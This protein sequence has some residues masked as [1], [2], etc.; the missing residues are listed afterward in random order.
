MNEPQD[1][2]N[3]AENV[4]D[5][6][7]GDYD[8][9]IDDMVIPQA[10]EYKE[11]EIKDKFDSGFKFAFI[12]TGQGGSRIAETFHKIGYRRVGVV[13][14]AEQDLATIDLPA[15]NKFCFG[16]GGAGKNRSR[17]KKLFSGKQEDC[18][19]FMKRVI[20]K[21]YDRTIICAGA[22]G[23]T[24]AGTLASLINVAKDLQ[25]VN[26]STSN[27][28]GV[29]LALPKYSEGKKV[30]ENAGKTL[31]EVLDLVKK[32]VVSPF[33]VL[34][35]E[36]IGGIYPNLSVDRFWHTANMSICTLFH[37]FNTIITKNSHYSTFDPND[38]QTILDS[39]TIVF[40]ATN[41]NDYSDETKISYAIR[42]NLKH[43]ILSGG[44]DLGTGTVAAS[45][46]IGK[47]D[48]LATIPEAHLDYAFE[49]LT[50]MLKSNSTVHRGIYR[51]NKAGLNIFTAIGGLA[52]PTDKI[53]DLKNLS[54]N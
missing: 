21:K 8:I 41:I 13:N 2:N 14:T 28:V 23:G 6:V 15:S 18:L 30:N 33:I 46:V 17:A 45:V 49:Q 5:D 47:Q 3:E 50:R 40:G 7:F 35:N 43:N 53:D 52:P 51:G 48:V 11:D 20:G 10:V 36:K 54:D 32:G 44:F 38:Y 34:D 16:S 22:G 24:G 37:L 27:K 39:G 29:I 19:D 1:L 4:S 42:E 9:N 31:K 25:V 26:K 12:G